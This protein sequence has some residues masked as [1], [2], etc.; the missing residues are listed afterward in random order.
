MCFA[1]KEPSGGAYRELRDLADDGKPVDATLRFLW[2][3]LEMRQ[4][5]LLFRTTNS[6]TY[7]YLNVDGRLLCV[8]VA[9]IPPS[10][11]VED[12]CKGMRSLIESSRLWP[13]L[14]NLVRYQFV[15]GNAETNEL[16]IVTENFEVD[17]DKICRQ[18][19][20]ESDIREYVFEILLVRK[21]LEDN[22]CRGVCIKPRDLFMDSKG[23]IKVN[24]FLKHRQF[25]RNTPHKVYSVT[26][27]I[28][29][30]LK[31]L[32]ELT[33]KYNRKI[34]YSYEYKTFL[35]LLTNLNSNRVY[36]EA[37]LNHPWMEMSLSKHLS[38]DR[39][40]NYPLGQNK[41]SLNVLARNM[42]TPFV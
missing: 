1:R 26:N 8:K 36:V 9:K 17:F 2:D 12:V 29:Y 38:S 32:K 18:N 16:F 6:K 20:K 28:D 30:L 31:I 34:N 13:D 15:K 39:R 25:F 5:S 11:S 40:G 14:C 4:N 10:E 7:K 41:Y 19:H 3:E 24:N 27:E 21:V 37:L 35:N 33:Y 23:S 22:G 42:P